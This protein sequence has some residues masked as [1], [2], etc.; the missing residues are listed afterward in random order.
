VHTRS[1][2]EFIREVVSIGKGAHPVQKSVTK[3]RRRASSS[4][5]AGP[6]ARSYVQK[7]VKSKLLLGE[8]QSFVC[9]SK[10]QAA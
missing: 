5:F 9:Q 8:A 10:V 4:D 1:L 6:S 3:G 7:P 2:E